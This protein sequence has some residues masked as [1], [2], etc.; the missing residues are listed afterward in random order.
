M[1]SKPFLKKITRRIHGPMTFLWDGFSI[2]LSEPV[3]RFLKQHPEITVEPLPEYAHELNP[4]DKAWL[5]VKYDRLPNYAP[6]TLDE[7]RDCMILELDALQKKPKVLAWCIEQA[8]LKTR[9]L[10]EGA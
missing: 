3:N 8:G 10:I 5:Y 9:P 4:V 7:L 2:H 6:A 1:S